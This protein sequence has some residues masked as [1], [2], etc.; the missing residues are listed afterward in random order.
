LAVA[1][2]ANA[3]APGTVKGAVLLAT[4]SPHAGFK[5]GLLPP[6][7]C[8]LGLPFPHRNE[9]KRPTPRPA[10]AETEVVM[11]RQKATF[12][13]LQRERDK[14]AKAKAKRERR[15]ASPDDETPSTEAHAGAQRAEESPAVL[16]E[17]IAHVQRQF[18]NAEISFEEYE[19]RK[20]DLLGRLTI[21]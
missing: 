17:L 21:D 13:K 2:S 18:D 10:A 11:G 6:T 5:F 15:H 4:P 9:I 14:Q 12:G 8:G 19:Q 20:S 3:A 7:R 1:G 16:L